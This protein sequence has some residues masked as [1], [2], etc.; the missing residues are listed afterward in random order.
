[1]RDGRPARRYYR[2]TA[3]GVRALDEAATTIAQLLPG[4]GRAGPATT[5]M[6]RRLAHG[7]CLRSASLPRRR[8]RR[9]PMRGAEW[10]VASGTPNAHA[11]V[12]WGGRRP[13]QRPGAP[14][15]ALRRRMRARRVAALGS[16]EAR[17]AAAGHPA[18]R[19]RGLRQR[20][21]VRDH[22]GADT[23]DRHRRQR[24]DLQCRARGAVAAAAVSRAGTARAACSRPPSRAPDRPGGTASPP[25]FVD[26]RR[27]NR[28]LHRTG[29]DQRGLVRADWPGRRRASARRR[30]HR[31][32]SSMCSAC[33]P[34]YGRTLLPEDEARG[35]A[36]YGGARPRPVVATIRRRSCRGRDGR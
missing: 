1:M 14:G 36:G 7:P 4:R 15:R 29:G 28:E 21:G 10:R 18:T 8:R 16:M 25:D 23:G 26:W 3:A 6:A 32:R 2:V 35:R 9:R 33:Q 27:D 20:P 31:R 34:S 24:G 22:D 19:S 13:A 17:D 30:G 12:A 11:T 5:V